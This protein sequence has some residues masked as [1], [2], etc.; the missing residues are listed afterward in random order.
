MRL[1][2]GEGTICSNIDC[3]VCVVEYREFVSADGLV[4]MDVALI[5]VELVA[6]FAALELLK[7]HLSALLLIN[8]VEVVAV[9]EVVGVSAAMR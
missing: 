2:I 9:V 1:F 6:H 7:R 3:L 8:V 5:A 4:P